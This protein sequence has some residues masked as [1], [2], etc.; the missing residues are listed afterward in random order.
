MSLTFPGPLTGAMQ[1]A[2]G[3]RAATV[4]GGYGVVPAA[5]ID[6]QHKDP[7]GARPMSAKDADRLM[8]AEL[9]DALRSLVESTTALSSRIGRRGA[10][11][12]V[13]DVFLDTIPTVGYIQRDYPVTVGSVGVINHH[14]SQPVIVQSGQPNGTTAPATGRGVQRIEPGSYLVM[15]VGDR[16]FTIWGT[17]TTILSVQAFTGLQPWGAGVL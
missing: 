13:L 6:T 2:H 12:G 8:T 9:L 4:A 14:A 5:P 1:E 11:N 3:Q 16:A 10:T 7:A 17:A 15:P